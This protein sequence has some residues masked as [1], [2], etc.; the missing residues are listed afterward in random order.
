M[1]KCH[2]VKMEFQDFS[3]KVALSDVETLR[4][5]INKSPTKSF[6]THLPWKKSTV[7]RFLLD[8]LLS[9]RILGF[10]IFSCSLHMN[11]GITRRGCV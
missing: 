6:D 5:V 1:S 2:L 7:K 11:E 3:V 9:L 4:G 8:V 10:R